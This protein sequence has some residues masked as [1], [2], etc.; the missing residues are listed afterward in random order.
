MDALIAA[1]REFARINRIF[2]AYRDDLAGEWDGPLPALD[3]IERIRGLTT[4][5]SI[6]VVRDKAVQGLLIAAAVLDI[7]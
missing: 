3:G 6:R 2:E 5:G 1:A 4:Y 7:P